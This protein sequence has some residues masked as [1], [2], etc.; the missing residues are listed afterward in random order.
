M[1]S[2]HRASIAQP[3]AGEPGAAIVVELTNPFE[4]SCSGIFARV[5][6]LFR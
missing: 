2:E 3:Q 4:N 5:R 1:K 6:I